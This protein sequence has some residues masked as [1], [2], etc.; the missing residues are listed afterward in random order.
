M[1]DAGWILPESQ[2]RGGRKAVERK[3]LPLK[4]GVNSAK[5]L[6]T[7]TA[8]MLLNNENLNLETED[9]VVIVDDDTEDDILSDFEEFTE[10]S[11]HLPVSFLRTD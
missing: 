7:P 6:S 3:S 8:T 5:I 11:G 9:A 2:K 10:R 4:R 1:F